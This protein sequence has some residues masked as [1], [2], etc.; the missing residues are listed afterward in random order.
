MTFKIVALKSQDRIALTVVDALKGLPAERSTD[1]LVVLFTREEV[2][3][4]MI[5]CMN[6]AVE[7]AGTQ[8]G[9]AAELGRRMMQFEVA[10]VHDQAVRVKCSCGG[11]IEDE[12]GESD[13]WPRRLEAWMD[14]H[15]M[16]LPS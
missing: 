11:A 9:E 12:P 6:A 1:D 2:G 10:F 5:Q 14:E 4:L 8:A 7:L 16:H 3:A 13:N 15:E